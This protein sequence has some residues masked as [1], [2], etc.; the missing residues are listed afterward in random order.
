MGPPA[1]DPTA[2][3]SRVHAA[4]SG[5]PLRV[6]LDATP[7]MN[8]RTGVGAVTAALFRHIGR[9]DDI[10]LHGYVVSWRARNRY[11]E[12]MP[13]GVAALRMPWPARLTHR[14]WQRTDHPRLRGSFDVVH[15]TNY[16][17][18]PTRRGTRLL[19]VH[20][21]T[22]WRFPTLVDHHSRANPAL[23]GRAVAGGA[24]I[25]CVSN[26]VGREVIE[27]LGVP[28]DRVHVIPNGFD[29]V[30]SGDATAART[31]IGGPYVLAVGTVEP[32][33]DYVGL[34]RAMTAVWEDHQDLRL[35]IVG[36]DGWGIDEFNDVVRT[37]GS[38]DRIVRPGYVT[39]AEKA[40]LIA[41][42]ELL[43][44]PSVYEGFGLPVLEA[45]AAGLPVVAT[46][47]D[48]VAEVAGDAAALVA[49]GDPGEL[50]EAIRSV[51][52]DTGR[53]ST[54]IAAGRARATE[55]SWDRTGD[56]MIGLYRDLADR[57]GRPA[58]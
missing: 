51:L 55:Y 12:M 39:E 54:L 14:L 31:R 11:R 24:S 6:A 19:T 13:D 16:V 22:A 30:G 32:R 4:E 46:A 23:F 26:A 1:A 15:G 53:R 5:A 3:L 57:V 2:T 38:A 34:V 25:H 50:G 44:Y 21:L 20:D 41:G 36:G 52:T 58:N 10:D 42:A 47:V 35:V 8:R 40:D 37:T 33:K 27:E 18:P 7:L 56:A 9:S 48:A 45:M 49:P 28:A 17:V 29:P 43:A